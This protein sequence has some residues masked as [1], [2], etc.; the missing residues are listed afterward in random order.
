MKKTNA[1]TE[2][3]KT[4]SWDKQAGTAQENAEWAK[5]VA[6]EIFDAIQH[7]GVGNVFFDFTPSLGSQAAQIVNSATASL[8]AELVERERIAAIEGQHKCPELFA[9][10]VQA[11]KERDSLRARNAQ[12]EEEIKSLG[13]R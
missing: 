3:T 11:C 8:R 13:E 4:E 5:G 10:Y 2:K 7:D 12:L 1:N 9:D 6:K